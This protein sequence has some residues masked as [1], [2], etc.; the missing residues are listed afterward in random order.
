MGAAARASRALQR[1][2]LVARHP[3]RC[4]AETP[5]GLPRRV[6]L[7]AQPTPHPARRLPNPARPRSR[8]R[9][10]HLRRDHPPSRKRLRGAR[11]ISMSRDFTFDLNDLADRLSP[12]TKLVVLNSPQN[13]TGG[14]IPPEVM[15]GAAELL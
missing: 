4:L 1:Q 14:V 5:A 15:A 2:D 12:R 11:Q 8:P 9:T 10:D 3:S 13:P 6:R 7:P